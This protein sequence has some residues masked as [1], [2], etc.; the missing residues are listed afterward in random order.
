[1]F[2]KE[3]EVL[4]FD[5][6]KADG[7]ETLLKRVREICLRINGEL[8]ENTSN[9]CELIAYYY[10]DFVKN[11]YEVKNWIFQRME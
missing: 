10:Y 4:E 3:G 2:A 6:K 11:T 9:I 7:E 8:I 1:M 5:E